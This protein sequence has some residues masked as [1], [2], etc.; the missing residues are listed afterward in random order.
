MRFH[1]GLVPAVAACAGIIGCAGPAAKTI[2][3]PG[4]PAV[5]SVRS[6]V[7]P[8]VAFRV[9]V[10]ASSAPGSIRIREFDLAHVHQLAQAIVN[11]S[12]GTSTCTAVS[13]GTMECAATFDVSAGNDTF[14]V[15]SF[16]GANATGSET[17][18]ILAYETAV[19]AVRTNV[20]DMALG[21]TAASI[22]LTLKPGSIFATGT[23]ASGFAFGGN[24]HNAVQRLQ[25][26]AL[27]AAGNVIINPGAPKLRLSAT[28]AAP[29]SI[30]TAPVTSNAF[31]LT[32]L[33]QTA[34]PVLLTATATP[35]GA[36][37]PIDS[38][39]HVALDPILYVINCWNTT[40]T[41]FAPW[42]T[43]PILTLTSS[44]SIEQNSAMALD[45]AG[46]LFLAN[47][48]GSSGD[49]VGVLEFAPGRT[50]ASRS[51]AGLNQP[52][53]LAIDASGDVFV[54]E[55]DQDVKEF[56]PSGG[57]TP[58]RVLSPTTSPAG[59]D[60]PEG[61]A[62]DG[63]GNLYVANGSGSI[64][65]SVYAPGSSTTPS[66]TFSNGMHQ[67]A[68]LAFDASNHLYVANVSGNDVTEYAAPFSAG[69][70]VLHAFGSS[71]SLNAPLA[72]AVDPSSNIYVVNSSSNAVEISQS[73]A[74]VR[75][76]LGTYSG[77]NLV[78]VDP[79]GKVYLPNESGGPSSG[80]AAEV[81]APGSTS[82]SPVY[83]DTGGP[84]DVVVWP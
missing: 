28:P 51:I 45:A 61:L 12:P 78:A 23:P 81:Y 46:N 42:S 21:G 56:T 9:T 70:K 39:V 57:S 19:S 20:I 11:V 13:A 7:R 44:S 48:V 25:V 30:A 5:P 69:T 79:L 14:D 49:A 62:V 55:N 35:R 54:N 1:R 16:N 4:P 29:L 36:G 60:M 10:P 41:A 26:V 37:T 58:S 77:T 65:V 59:I 6:H 71:A 15:A 24:G 74:V 32:P 2:V 8:T 3:P 67:P 22:A 53:F 66:V 40:V 17:I 76:F 83:P 34:A 75:S 84:M 68:W 33:A 47:D 52:R 50:V 72:L 80:G 64:G 73:N 27:D 38:T 63:S 82:P 18:G 43:A 31:D